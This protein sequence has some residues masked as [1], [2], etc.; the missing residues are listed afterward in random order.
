MIHFI[1]NIISIDE[2][3]ILSE[4]FYEL[5]KTLPNIDVGDGFEYTFA[6]KPDKTDIFDD[7]LEKLK[8]QEETLNSE[9][10]KNIA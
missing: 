5:K 1:P 6:F 10:F 2:S 8:N 7:Y 3:K 4:R 9:F